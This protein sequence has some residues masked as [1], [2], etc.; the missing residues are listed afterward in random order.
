MQLFISI[1]VSSTYIQLC[2]SEKWFEI[3][4]I[5]VL[6][7]NIEWILHTFTHTHNLQ[8]WI[9][10]ASVS[11]YAF[12]R[13]SVFIRNEREYLHGEYYWSGNLNC[14]NE[15]C[16]MCKCHTLMVPNKNKFNLWIYLWRRTISSVSHAYT[17]LIQA[18]SCE[19]CTYWHRQFKYRRND[20]TLIKWVNWRA[21]RPLLS[22]FRN[23]LDFE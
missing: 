17:T 12:E 4:Q 13:F 18:I 22:L 15:T 3:T 2:E 7:K 5:W 14:A 9:L 23:W 1:N 6:S 10:L 20:G 21:I 16:A 8:L 11:F 19:W